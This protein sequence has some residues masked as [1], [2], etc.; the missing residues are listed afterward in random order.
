MMD[1]KKCSKMGSEMGSEINRI[2]KLN[3]GAILA[4][5]TVSRFFHTAFVRF[6]FRLVFVLT[7]IEGELCVSVY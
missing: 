6:L 2:N 7:E 3:C 4:I 1:G 5:R